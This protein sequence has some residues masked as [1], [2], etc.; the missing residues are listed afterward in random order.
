MKIAFPGLILLLRGSSE[1]H[2]LIKIH[3]KKSKFSPRERQ[4]YKPGWRALSWHRSETGVGLTAAVDRCLN[5]REA[6]RQ[7]SNSI[8][9]SGVEDRGEEEIREPRPRFGVG[10]YVAKML[11]ST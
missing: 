7:V 3:N 6:R 11:H 10:G 4:S 1:K 8:A 2:Q 5:D 9:A